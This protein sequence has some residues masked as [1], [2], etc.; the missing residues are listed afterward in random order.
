M[1]RAFGAMA[2][3]CS[4]GTWGKKW[5]VNAQSKI[6]ARHAEGLP[7]TLPNSLLFDGLRW[8]Y[9]LP[10]WD[11]GLPLHSLSL[12]WGGVLKEICLD[13]LTSPPMSR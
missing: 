11:S 4:L 3:M 1:T 13:G 10:A 2:F 12:L 6:E 5:T 7:T 8:A 9:P